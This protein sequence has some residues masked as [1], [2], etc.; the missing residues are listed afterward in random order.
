MGSSVGVLSRKVGRRSELF[1]LESALVDPDVR[2]SRDRIEALLHPEFIELG[3][4]GDV[5]DRQM[6][7]D[8]LSQEVSAEVVIRDFETRVVSKDTVLVT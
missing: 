1:D 4:S 6:I 3:S 2:S 5:Y 7:I 8:M